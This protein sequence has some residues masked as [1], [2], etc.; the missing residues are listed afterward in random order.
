MKKNREYVCGIYVIKNII[1]GKCYV[2]QSIDI[3]NRWY[4]HQSPKTWEGERGKA[5]YQAFKKYGIENFEFKIIEKC[6][7]NQLDEREKYW[8]SH[9]NSYNEGYNMTEGGQGNAKRDWMH[10]PKKKQSDWFS[11]YPLNLGGKYSTIYDTFED[12]KAC[13]GLD[14]YSLEDIDDEMRE[15]LDGYDTMFRDFCD[16]YDS[17]E[18]WAECNLI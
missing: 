11:G 16:G 8:I 6:P 9:F 2:G 3:Y 17:F 12:M 7:R 13:M 15:E 5:L 18:Q 10:R 1:N 14:F 4:K